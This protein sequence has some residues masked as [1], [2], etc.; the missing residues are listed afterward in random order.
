MDGL[1]DDIDALAE[2]HDFSGAV[3]VDGAGRPA[4]A[5]AYGLAHRAWEVPN[6]PDTRFAMASGSKAFTA[7][8][9]VGLVERGLLTLDTTARSLL[10][11][12]L[13]LIADDVTVGQL[14][15]HRSGI[16]DYLEEGDD[17]DPTDYLLS[18]PMQE[19]L[20]TEQFL[21]V[22]DGFPTAF[23]AG[24]RWAYN[25][26]GY[27]VLALLAERAAGI[28]YHDLVQDIVF[29]PAGMADSGFFRSDEL[30]G[31]TALGYLTD[32]GPRTNVFH[33]P[34]R[35][36]GDGGAYTTLADMGR[37][38]QAFL[39]G[40]I[41]PPGRVA[42]M[43]HPHTADTGNE[44]WSYGLG[45]WLYGSGGAVA[46]EGSDAGVSFRSGHHPASGLTI[47]VLCNTSEGAWNITRRLMPLLDPHP[48]RAPADAE[49]AGSEPAG[50]PADA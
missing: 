7:L 48:A 43:T 21:A 1:A 6:T 4:L 34:V 22:L 42:E 18:V 35:G 23:P 49:P 5:R 40:R 39:A 25:N 13:P 32:D 12:D 17:D 9:V 20:T 8:A 33:L 37:F 38:W 28:P 15:A 2:E 30:P 29:T 3:S 50:A 47:T 14:L 46:L 45:F 19:L 11:G 27:V 44:N 41:V 31:R 36:N 24:E 16:G 26:G 10:G